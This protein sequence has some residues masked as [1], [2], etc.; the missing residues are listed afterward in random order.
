MS[1]IDISYR[2]S[3]EK[4]GQR[5]INWIFCFG[6]ICASERQ[7][8]ASRVYSHMIKKERRKNLR[9]AAHSRAVFGS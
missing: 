9:S 1:R 8:R 6:G 4:A 5:W 7:V 3:G 2:R